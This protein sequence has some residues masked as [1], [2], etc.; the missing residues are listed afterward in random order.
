MNMYI[1]ISTI[2]III[3]IYNSP[4]KQTEQLD[5]AAEHG[6]LLPMTTFSY[7]INIFLL[8]YIQI[9]QC[10]KSNS[11]HKLFNLFCTCL[12]SKISYIQLI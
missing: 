3:I 4:K 11:G 1:S 6:T 8:I 7:N 2:I 12:I 10:S 5:A 9:L